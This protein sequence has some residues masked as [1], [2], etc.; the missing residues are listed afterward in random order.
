M[1]KVYS[2]DEVFADP[3]VLHR[4]MWLEVEH[5]TEGKINQLGIAVKLSDTPGAI[6]RQAPVP[7]EHTVEILKALGYDEQSINKLCREGIISQ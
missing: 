6:R 7:G 2:L 3:H 4:K 1:A 5:P